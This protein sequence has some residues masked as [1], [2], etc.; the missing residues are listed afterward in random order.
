LEVAIELEAEEITL[1][2]AAAL[3]EL[4]GMS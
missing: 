4:S 2:R 3:A 1:A